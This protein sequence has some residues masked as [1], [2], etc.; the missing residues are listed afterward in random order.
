M[1]PAAEPKLV[2]PSQF[3]GSVGYYAL[4]HTFPRVAIDVDAPFDKRC[5]EVHR[6]TI[7]DTHG[8]KQLTIPICKP[9]SMTAARW[10]DIV[11]SDH[12]AWWHVHWE[13]LKSAYGRTPFFEFYADDFAPFFSS[14]MAGRK[15]TDYNAALDRLLRRLLLIDTAVDF[16]VRHGLRIEPQVDLTPYYQVRSLTQGFI[17][18]LSAIDLLFNLGPEAALYLDKLSHY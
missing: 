6:C 13:T 11:I 14:S 4:M 9:V 7:A 15:L 8:T 16:D 1:T 5:K 10:S 17:P 2:L 3:L 12:G 18:G